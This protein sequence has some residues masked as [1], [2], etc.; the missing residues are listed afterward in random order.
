M[1]EGEHRIGDVEELDEAD[2]VIADVEGREIAVFEVD[3]EYHGVANYCVHQS[4]PLCEGELVGTTS[5][6]ETSWTYEDDQRTV[7]CPWHGWAF[8]VTTGYN[9]QDDRYAVPTYDV[10]VRDGGLYVRL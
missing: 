6:T 1:A 7:V 4:G 3:G 2:R 8:D 9:V 5:R 10:E